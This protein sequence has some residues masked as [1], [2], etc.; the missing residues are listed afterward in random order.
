MS[1][2]A[3]GDPEDAGDG[4]RSPGG[5]AP[6]P[7]GRLRGRI[8]VAASTAALVALLAAGAFV[9]ASVSGADRDALDATLTARADQAATVG[10]RTLR[11]I[12]GGP[13]GRPVDRATRRVARL[14]GRVPGGGDVALI[15]VVRGGAVL[16]SLG[17][18]EDPGLPLDAPRGPA[19]V[20]TA[21]G[22][23]RIVQRP[24][25]RG[26]VVQAASPLAPPDARRATLRDRLLL[27]GA[28]GVLATGALAFLLAGPALAALTRLRRDAGRVVDT[29]DLGVRMRDDA[30]P[31]E[32]RELAGTLNAMLGRLAVSDD[33][34]RRA[35]EAS[36]SFAADAGHELRTPL[37]ALTTTV[38]TLRAHPDLAA[39]E[40][41]TMLAEVAEEHARLVDLLDALQALARG[42][43]GA[44]LERGPVDL[45]ELAEQAVGAAR[46]AAPGVRL[47]LDAP[48]RVLVD[49]WAP[50]LRLA[51]DNLVTNAVRHGRPD[52]TVVVTITGDDGGAIVLV[53]DDGPGV[54]AD[55]RE[56]VLGR[57]ARGRGTT[58][59]GSGLGLALVDQQARLH[60]GRLTLEDAPAGGL[61]ARMVLGSPDVRRLTV[62]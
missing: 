6:G 10:R 44:R 38:Q 37:S 49:G 61:R 27:A 53:D 17:A 19:T 4:E 46:A 41:E 51:L 20:A 5:P 25:G 29:A 18:G 22:A 35:F 26:V 45:A 56:A 57:F 1:G 2:R 16:S 54:P 40:R 58:A 55:Q 24:M 3:P 9:L 7:L 52:G 15:R 28:G 30:G 13:A 39:D 59:P 62:G 32:V 31:A 8:A 48:P 14:L 36:R 34:R 50:G 23:W 33:E 12:A 60:G 21:S 43:A 11:G 47:V 42:D